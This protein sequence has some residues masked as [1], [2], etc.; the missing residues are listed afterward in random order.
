MQKV[1]LEYST[2]ISDFQIITKQGIPGS[3]TLLN[4]IKNVYIKNS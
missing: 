3:G 2:L 1:I 4:M